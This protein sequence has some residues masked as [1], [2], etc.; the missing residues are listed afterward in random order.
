MKSVLR[1]VCLGALLNVLYFLFWKAT[2]ITIIA[3]IVS[4]GITA[5]IV[6]LYNKKLNLNFLQIFQLSVGIGVA[7][8]IWGWILI[9]IFPP[10]VIRDIGDIIEPFHQCFMNGMAT[11]AMIPIINMVKY[12]KK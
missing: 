8:I 4:I 10:T 12:L 2:H 5:G 11:I 3:L 1:C 9:I 7:Y 6:F